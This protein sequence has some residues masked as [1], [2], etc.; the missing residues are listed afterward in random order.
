MRTFVRTRISIHNADAFV[1]HFQGSFHDLT[2]A[3]LFSDSMLIKESKRKFF[4]FEQIFSKMF[5]SK[6]SFDKAKPFLEILCASLNPLSKQQLMN[7]LLS[8][9]I[10]TRDAFVNEL[11]RLSPFLEIYMND[12]VTF[13]HQSVFEWLR[14]DENRLFQI[15]YK[16][17]HR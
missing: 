15:H 6:T 3:A 8:E 5:S 10:L 17:G 16:N 4:V 1:E 9:G 2:M 13:H 7:M 11:N 12:D 14:S